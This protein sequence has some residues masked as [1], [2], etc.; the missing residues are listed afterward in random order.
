[1]IVND[2]YPNIG[3][4]KSNDEIL[5]AN[6]EEYYNG[7]ACG[8]HGNSLLYKKVKEVINENGKLIILI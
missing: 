6:Q 8:K 4:A 1:M 2:I 3:D 5:V 7:A